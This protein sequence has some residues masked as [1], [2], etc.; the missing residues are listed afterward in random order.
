MEV[1]DVIGFGSLCIDF[2]FKVDKYP[3]RGSSNLSRTSIVDCGGTIGNFLV[4]CSRLGLKCG[5]MGIVGADHYG[6]MIV[7]RLT[8]SGID[9]SMLIIDE[10]R[11]TAKVVCIVDG[12]GER[13][14]IVDPGAQAH[15]E[16][17]EG[18]QEYVTKCRAFHTDCLNV[19][20]ASFLLREAKRRGIMTSADVGFLA[21]HALRGIEGGWIDNIVKWCDLVFVSKANAKKL[22]PGLSPLNVLDK[23]IR[24]GAGLAVVTLGKKGCVVADGSKFFRVRAF[25]VVDTTG[26]GDA[27]EA[28]FIFSFLKGSTQKT[29][30]C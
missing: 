25:E 21:E 5:V 19:N 9:T 22:F 20:Q 17:P 4:G 14:F 6:Q 7:E 16:L 11:S 10:K 23:V 1:M 30:L 29:Q 24:Q 26:A 3:K 28:G 27:F 2:V 13:T 8:S 18:A 15:V 12:R